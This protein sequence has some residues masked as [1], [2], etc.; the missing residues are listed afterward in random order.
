MRASY[1][2]STGRS[3]DVLLVDAVGGAAAALRAVSPIVTVANAAAQA[4]RIQCCLAAIR[5]SPETRTRRE[6]VSFEGK[7]HALQVLEWRIFL[8]A[9][10]YPLPGTCADHRAFCATPVSSFRDSAIVQCVGRNGASV[11]RHSRVGRSRCADPGAFSVPPSG[12]ERRAL[13]GRTCRHSM[14]DFA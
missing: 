5:S 3:V 11:L 8:S 9:N 1:S 2:G 4:N 14:V 13:L 10:R 6:R 7:E 12:C